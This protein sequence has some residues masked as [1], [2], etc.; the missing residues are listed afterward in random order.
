RHRLRVIRILTGKPG[1]RTQ[2]SHTAR[3]KCRLRLSPPLKFVNSIEAEYDVGDDF[4]IGA[5][6]NARLPPNDAQR[7]FGKRKV[8]R[9][10]ILCE[11]ARKR[12]NSV[13]A[14]LGMAH[15][16]DFALSRAG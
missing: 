7:G 12:P 9:F 1:R 11:L 5:Q 16:S 2:P 14:D 6:D 8:Q 4:W 3:V 15:R 13:F 10:V